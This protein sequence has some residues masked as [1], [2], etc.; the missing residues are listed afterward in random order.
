MHCMLTIVYHGMGRNCTAD[1]RGI[2]A[3]ASACKKTNTLANPPDRRLAIRGVARQ[4]RRTINRRVGTQKPFLARLM[5]CVNATTV[6]EDPNFGSDDYAASDKCDVR[7]PTG[8][9]PRTVVAETRSVISNKCRSGCEPSDFPFRHQ[10]LRR[11]R[12]VCFKRLVNPGIGW[13]LFH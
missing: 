6:V 13:Q 10:L 4:R 8:G 12:V 9:E 11:H 3:L 7:L 2:V 5:C 1:D